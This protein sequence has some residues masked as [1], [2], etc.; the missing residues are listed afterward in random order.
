MIITPMPPLNEYRSSL[1]KRIK[2]KAIQRRD[3][4]KGLAFSTLIIADNTRRFSGKK[5]EQLV[6][7]LLTERIKRSV[8]KSGYREVYLLTSAEGS[9]YYFPLVMAT[10]LSELCMFNHTLVNLATEDLDPPQHMRLFRQFMLQRGFRIGTPE[11][12]PDAMILGGVAVTLDADFHVSVLDHY[13]CVAPP[14]SSPATGE[15]SGKLP[16]GFMAQYDRLS[17]ANEFVSP[18]GFDARLNG[19]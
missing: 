8:E 13:D 2:T 5:R 15:L 10:L 1:V 4:P 7:A 3:Y 14:Q 19:W 6:G 12:D 9:I 18:L 16:E 17:A 11:G